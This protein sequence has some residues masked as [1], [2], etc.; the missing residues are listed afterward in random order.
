M[1]P[2][3]QRWGHTCVFLV[4]HFLLPVGQ[5]VAVL[6]VVERHCGF[7]CSLL[8][9]FF[10]FQLLLLPRNACFHVY[11]H[12]ALA[13]DVNSGKDSFLSSELFTPVKCNHF[14][15]VFVHEPST[16]QGE[17]S[18]PINNGHH[19]QSSCRAP[20]HCPPFY[21]CCVFFS[22]RWIVMQSFLKEKQKL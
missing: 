4:L 22:L 12:T 11:S 5:C 21:S 8:F 1:Q 13:Q 16:E 7:D 6:K 18:V 19:A 17:Y 2:Y 20:L 14:W 15:C 9:C 10:L 3:V